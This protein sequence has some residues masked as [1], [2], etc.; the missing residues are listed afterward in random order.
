MSFAKYPLRCL[1]VLIAGAIAFPIFVHRLASSCG[2]AHCDT[3]GDGIEQ[4]ISD[5]IEELCEA[6]MTAIA[7]CPCESGCPSCIHSPKCGNNNHPLDKAVAKLI[8]RSVLGLEE[9]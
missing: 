2:L 7:D 9:S 6:T 1:D 4:Q 5:V 8:L 3:I